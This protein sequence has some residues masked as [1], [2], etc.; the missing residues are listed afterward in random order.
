MSASFT[1]AFP[2]EI[3]TGQTQSAP[4]SASAFHDAAAVGIIS[5]ATLPETVRIQVHY[6]PDALSGDPAWVDLVD[7][8]G[9]NIETGAAGKA[10]WYTELPSF[11]AF[12]LVA[13][14]AVGGNRSFWVTKT[15]TV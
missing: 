7:S 5:P 9:T 13:A 15:F 8:G 2:V 11:G 6:N 14:V 10:K 12:R 1:G 3:L 4:V